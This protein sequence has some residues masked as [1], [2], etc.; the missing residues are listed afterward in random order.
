MASADRP[1]KLKIRT[2]TCGPIDE[3]DGEAIL[4]R[5]RGD[6]EI[7]LEISKTRITCSRFWDKA[8]AWNGFLPTQ[9]RSFTTTPPAVHLAFAASFFKVCPTARNPQMPRKCSDSGLIDGL[10]M[11]TRFHTRFSHLGSCPFASTFAAA[12][13]RR[14]DDPK[15]AP[16]WVSSPRSSIIRS[17]AATNQQSVREARARDP[18]PLYDGGLGLKPPSL[19]RFLVRGD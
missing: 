1:F 3:E 17:S 13:F 4:S 14:D 5:S 9:W 2:N 8:R 12:Y 18:V 11:L 6:P 15:A 7:P 10:L 19:K 16:V